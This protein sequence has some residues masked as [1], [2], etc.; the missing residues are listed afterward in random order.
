MERPDD[1]LAR[2]SDITVATTTT[3]QAE[4]KGF[5]AHVVS[6]LV[7]FVWTF[8]ALT[9]DRILNS[10]GVWYYPSRWWALASPAWILVTMGY[11][12]L[13]LALVNSESVT[14]QLH[15]IRSVVDDTGV[16]VTQKN[17]PNNNLHLYSPTNGV[18][19]LPLGEVNRVLYSLPAQ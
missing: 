17:A 18:W 3:P 7:L 4:Y 8:W 6:L 15:D 19:D 9:P 1:D 14:L 2:V 16:V 11:G 12:Y 13:A 10:L 5:A